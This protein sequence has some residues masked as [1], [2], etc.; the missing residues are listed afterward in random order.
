MNG[1]EKREKYFENSDGVKIGLLSFP[2]HSTA[3]RLI[4][5]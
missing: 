5:K 2:H 1:R 3:M 4:H